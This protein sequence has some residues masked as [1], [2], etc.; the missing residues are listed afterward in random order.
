MIVYTLGNYKQYLTVW[1]G[2]NKHLSRLV[3]TFQ[4]QQQIDGSSAQCP[5]EPLSRRSP[6]SG[7]LECSLLL[8]DIQT[9][10][11]LVFNARYKA[12]SFQTLFVDVFVSDIIRQQ[13]SS[14]VSRYTIFRFK[15]F[16]GA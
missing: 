15:N 1:S 13:R 7:K 14:E 2:W 4:L 16:A 6:A 8:P 9:N 11:L 3:L 12:L 10:H 5:P